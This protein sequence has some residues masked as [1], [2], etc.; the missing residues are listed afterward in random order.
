MKH[1]LISLLCL[2]S[3]GVLMAQEVKPVRIHGKIQDFKGGLVT[4]DYYATRQSDTVV[5]NADGTFDYSGTVNEPQQGAL[6]FEDYKC[7]VNLF[8][9]NGMDARLNISFVQGDFEG[10]VTYEPEVDY[11]GDNADCTAFMDG[12]MDWWL[13]ESPWPLHGFH[14]W[15]Y[16]LVAF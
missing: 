9:E 11:Q 3:T 1:V 6:S 4:V 16:G 5:V 7:S 8:V 14:G 13:F 12:Y 2:L 10:M 15:L